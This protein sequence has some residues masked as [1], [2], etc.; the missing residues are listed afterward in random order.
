MKYTTGDKVITKQGRTGTVKHHTN[1]CD[2]YVVEFDDGEW[3]Y[4]IESN[5][6]DNN[7][8]MSN[9]IRAMD[10]LKHHKEMVAEIAEKMAKN[11]AE[12]GCPFD[13]GPLPSGRVVKKITIYIFE[14]HNQIGASWIG[15]DENGLE[16]AFD[17]IL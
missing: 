5:L 1:N 14:V 9:F 10:G 17:R 3:S 12:N 7:M 11:P 8:T 15:L 4:V 2:I 6:T 13:I 16:V